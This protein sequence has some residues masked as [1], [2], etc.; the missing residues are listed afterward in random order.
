MDAALGSKFLGTL[1]GHFSLLLHLCLVAYQVDSHILTCV[2]LDFFEPF[3][4][5][6]EGVLA[7][8]I[9]GEEHAMRT[10]VE[11]AGDRLE[12]LLSGCVPD[13]Q[14]D[15]LSPVYLQPE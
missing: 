1:E 6:H 10:S 11:D 4:K 8:H 2:L 7:R 14:L 15:Y 9:I 3:H 13:L 12:G 5:V